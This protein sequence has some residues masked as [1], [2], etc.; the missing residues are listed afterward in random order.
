MADS[1]AG[2]PAGVA[3]AAGL[4][5]RLHPLTLLRPKALC[6]VG[7][8]PLLDRALDALGGACAELAVNAHHR[9]DDI[10]AHLEARGGGPVHLSI[11]HPEPLGTAGALAALAGWLDG[12]PALV[13]NS[14][15]WHRAD[16]VAFVADWDGH[17]PAV[18]TPTPGP[19]G[20]RSGVVASLVPSSAVAAL[21]AE[22]SG[23]WE[24]LWRPALDQGHL[25]VVHHTGTVVDCATPADYLRA[26]MEC[27][28]GR[29]VVGEGAVVHGTLERSVVWPGSRVERG[30]RLVDAIRAGD[31]T[32]LVR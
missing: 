24:V 30:E 11:E 29:P 8:R 28:A 12:R 16:L 15:T 18:L 13:V 2:P 32:V 9:A 31:R 5:T 23:L 3:L 4:G 6:P 10:A 25:T 21:R 17:H 26:N 14:D 19:F 22:P 20:P 1:L 7:D 27:S